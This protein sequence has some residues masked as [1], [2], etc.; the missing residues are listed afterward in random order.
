MTLGNL[1]GRIDA[2]LYHD[3]VRRSSHFVECGHDLRRDGALPAATSRDRGPCSS[4]VEPSFVVRECHTT[5][6]RRS[7]RSSVLGML[8]ECSFSALQTLNCFSCAHSWLQSSTPE[9]VCPANSRWREASLSSRS[10][11]SSRWDLWFMLTA[12]SPPMN[13]WAEFRPPRKAGRSLRATGHKPDTQLGCSRRPR[14]VVCG[15]RLLG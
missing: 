4:N 6:L 12:G 15:E 9:H 13:R 8:S 10:R 5:R 7:L 3:A 2:R 14:C 1:I 11:P